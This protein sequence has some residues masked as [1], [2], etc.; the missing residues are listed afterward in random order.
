[1]KNGEEEESSVILWANWVNL[2]AT[3]RLTLFWRSVKGMTCYPFLGIFVYHPSEE[4]SSNLRASR[5]SWRYNYT[6]TYER[7]WSLIDNPQLKSIFEHF[8]SISILLSIFLLLRMATN[9]RLNYTEYHS[10]WN[11]KV[12]YTWW[13]C[14]ISASVS[15]EEDKKV[16]LYE[17]VHIPLRSFCNWRRP[18][19]PPLGVALPPDSSRLQC[20]T[21]LS[22]WRIYPALNYTDGRARV[23]EGSSVVRRFT[24]LLS[25]H[26][27]LIT[28][29]VH[30]LFMQPYCC[31]G[32]YGNR[33]PVWS[34][35]SHLLWIS[36]KPPACFPLLVV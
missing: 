8:T 30:A 13:R 17:S 29:N 28:S 31:S 1:M 19:P 20:K 25:S 34:T 21:T 22:A 12:L 4:F 5:V 7:P 23:D 27:I 36:S 15:K 18:M 32:N 2:S 14:W 10:Y 33:V 35:A 3:D 9:K 24:G 6:I 26:P 16:T 11:T